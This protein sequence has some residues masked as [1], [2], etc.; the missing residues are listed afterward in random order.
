M[1][2]GKWAQGIPPRNFAWIMADKLAVCERPGG[3]GDNHRKVRRQ[4]EIIWLRENG[5]TCVVSII[6][7]PHNLHNYTD[8]GVV[9][10]H[11]PFGVHDDA[12]TYLGALYPELKGLLDAGGKLALHG[13][14]LSDRLC[15]L[16]AGYLVWTGMVPEG[17]RAT[18]IIEQITKRQIGSTGR[19]LIAVAAE[20]S[21][22]S[23]EA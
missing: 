4:E 22:R 11:R 14:E 15:G 16:I 12:P 2:K 5:F 6:P 9:W 13:E 1:V 21:G 8:M 18:M 10:R 23:T 20:L 7:A 3:Y 19:E 17:P